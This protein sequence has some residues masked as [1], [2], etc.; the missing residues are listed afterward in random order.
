[1]STQS[2]LWEAGA[3]GGGGATE[4]VSADTEWM[5]FG[6]RPLLGEVSPRRGIGRSVD[7]V[8]FQPEISHGDG[9]SGGG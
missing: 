4:R 9:W 3:R 1:M 8:R 2:W 7:N 5:K 6:G